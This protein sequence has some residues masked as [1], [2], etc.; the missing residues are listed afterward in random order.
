MEKRANS[1]IRGL[2]Q[3]RLAGAGQQ[4]VLRDSPR[5]AARRGT[6]AAP[7]E[8]AKSLRPTVSPKQEEV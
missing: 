4:E 3:N 5:G 7:A 1:T 6:R 2:S 8:T